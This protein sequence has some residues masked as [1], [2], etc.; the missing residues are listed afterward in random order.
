MPAFRISGIK[1]DDVD[2]VKY[3]LDGK[4]LDPNNPILLPKDITGPIKLRA[5]GHSKMIDA[6]FG[7]VCFI[8]I[9]DAEI[10]EPSSDK[11]H[12]AKGSVDQSEVRAL[13]LNA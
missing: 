10:V 2:E 12:N 3:W 11:T 8:S 1:N 4:E 5:R 9:I 13:Q 7:A 6:S